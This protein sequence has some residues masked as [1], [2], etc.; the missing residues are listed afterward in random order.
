MQIP[1][2]NVGYQ[3]RSSDI[4]TSRTIN[5][6][7]ELEDQ[8]SK[9]P[10]A[11]IGTPGTS[12]WKRVGSSP[13]RAMYRFGGYLFMV[14]G[15]TLYRVDSKSVMTTVGS[16]NTTSG[17]L[18]FVDNGI[19]AQGVG[20]NQMLILDGSYGYIYDLLSNT[21]ETH[22]SANFPRPAIAA[23]YMD[24]YFIVTG[25]NMGI[26]VSE[27]YD[28]STFNGL[29]IAAAIATPD[30]IKN[31]VNLH[32]Q[33]FIIKEYSTEVWYNAG[34]AT[35]DGCP[36][37]RV[38]GA[39]IDYGTAATHSV[40]RGNN[41]IYFLANQRIGDG[42]GS[43]IGVV[44]L[45]DYNPT[46]VTPPQIVYRMNQLTSISDAEAYCYNDEGHSFYVVTFPT[47]N[48]TFVYDS[49][50]QQW[51]ERS[52]YT[53]KRFVTFDSNGTPT[54]AISDILGQNR[55]LSSCYSYY[56]GKHLVGDYRTGNIYVMS[57]EY[58]TDNTEPIVLERTA[59][60][61][62]DAANKESVFVSRLIL[63]GEEGVGDSSVYQNAVGIGYLADG[64][65]FAD[66]SIFAGAYEIG[67]SVGSNPKVMLSWSD[68]SGKTW[69]NEYEG[70]M[71]K[72]G[73]YKARMIW[74]RLG[75][76]KDRVF[77]IRCS[78]PIK[79][80]FTAAFIEGSV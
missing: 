12:L 63:D 71:G 58:Y 17:P 53:S 43:F 78:A 22:P 73:E 70:S 38:P 35:Q 51:H 80:V 49:T 32:Q 3:G 7:I 42:S 55:H 50:T 74:R 67:E 47:D 40:A 1:F 61:L 11:L 76:S 48:V 13:M 19:A 72:I 60:I 45:K 46:L 4:N 16:L 65:Y 54:Y 25:G 36:F 10:L 57:T 31:L 21:F 44:E 8:S 75:A 62:I 14:S 41:A 52:T 69:S 20:G 77:R 2:I 9:T 56:S 6:F 27:L 30:N 37:A 24:G 5:C 68:D 39:I 34:V 28:G 64:T 18:T 29:A 66:G 26:T 15:A 59:P 23:A 33:L 79:K